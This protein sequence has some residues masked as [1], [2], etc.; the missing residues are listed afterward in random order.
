MAPEGL[1]ELPG[2]DRIWLTWVHIS[3]QLHGEGPCL[4]VAQRASKAMSGGCSYQQA[5]CSQEEKHLPEVR[6]HV[7]LGFRCMAASAGSLQ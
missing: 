6:P 4:L 2:G 5:A 3:A 7:Y 1:V